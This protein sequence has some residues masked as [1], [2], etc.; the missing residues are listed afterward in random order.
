MARPSSVNRIHPSLP[1]N[2]ILTLA[3]TA[4]SV[5]ALARDQE[6]A[7]AA[8]GQALPETPTSVDSVM[9]RLSAKLNLTSDQKAQIAPIVATRQRQ[10]SELKADTS[11]HRFSKMRKMKD[12]LQK[13]DQK[14]NAIL[15]DQ[16]KKQYEQMEQ[17]L[18]QELKQRKQ[19]GGA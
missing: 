16:Q 11:M 6:G 3:C 7:P 15:D 17:Q 2:L 4:L 19:R 18:R 14:I 12:I 9:A 13:S 8:Q 5:P 1:L 10:M